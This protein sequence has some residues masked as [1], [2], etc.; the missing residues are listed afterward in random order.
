MKFVSFERK[1]MYK[2]ALKE[3]LP[4]NIANDLLVMGEKAESKR[5]DWQQINVQYSISHYPN[6]AYILVSNGN[7]G[8]FEYSKRNSLLENRLYNLEIKQKTT[9]EEGVNGEITYLLEKID[10][11]KES[12]F[13]YEEVIY[14][15]MDLK[16]NFIIV[17]VE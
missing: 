2:K 1:K 12:Y 9:F 16:I 13:I 3:L 8:G 11:T 5:K 15:D 14:D 4:T 17:R 7:D 6:D 10:K